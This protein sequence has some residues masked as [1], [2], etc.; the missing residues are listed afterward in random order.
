MKTGGKATPPLLSRHFPPL[1]IR[2]DMLSSSLAAPETSCGSWSA[3]DLSWSHMHHCGGIELSFWNREG[4]DIRCLYLPT[5]L[6]GSGAAKLWVVLASGEKIILG[7][8]RSLSLRAFHASLPLC[9]SICPRLS[10]YLLPS[11]S[12]RSLRDSCAHQDEYG[13]MR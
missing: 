1:W 9:R 4:R 6:R 11:L 2:G 13:V 3:F 7:F 8:F 12:P 5:C 10:E